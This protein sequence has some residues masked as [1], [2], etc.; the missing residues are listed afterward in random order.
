MG[1]ELGNPGRSFRP[2]SGRDGRRCQICSRPAGAGRE[3]G[4]WKL[5]IS[6]GYTG[7]AETEPLFEL[8]SDR[9]VR[10]QG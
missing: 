8:D 3:D 9:Y 10:P 5:S 4:I 6:I 7:G 1:S 2:D